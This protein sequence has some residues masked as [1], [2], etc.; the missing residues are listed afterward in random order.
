MRSLQWG[1]HL[2]QEKGC[3]S[4]EGAPISVVSP[5][6]PKVTGSGG[7]GSS[8]SGSEKRERVADETQKARDSDRRKVL[9]AELRDATAR[10]E[11]LKKD[12]NDGQPERTDRNFAVHQQ[13]V[14][15]MR[16]AIARQ[17]ADVEALK[18]ELAKL[19]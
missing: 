17:E 12:F 10:L 2:T 11:Q 15:D 7:S 14:T 8:A 1:S 6:K 9:E 3:R 16:A 18:R 5:S 13:K 4:I 19:P